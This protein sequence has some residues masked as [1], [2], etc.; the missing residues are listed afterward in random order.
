MSYQI[1]LSPRAKRAARFIRSVH[2]EIQAAFAKASDATG[3][4]QQELANRLEVNRAT[5][6]KRLLGQENL[7]LRT[8]ADLA[9]ALDREPEFRLKDVSRPSHANHIQP[10]I[11]THSAR[12]ELRLPTSNEVGTRVSNRVSVRSPQVLE[13]VE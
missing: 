13:A 1:K 5:V 4:T 8:I 9:W 3:L 6:N 10:A 2:R 11:M 12:A 7:T